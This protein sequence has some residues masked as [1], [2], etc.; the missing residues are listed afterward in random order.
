[1]LSQA[2][3][4]DPRIGMGARGFVFNADLVSV[5]QFLDIG[6]RVDKSMR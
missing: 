5:V 6:T 2:Q 1:M 4:M 3:L